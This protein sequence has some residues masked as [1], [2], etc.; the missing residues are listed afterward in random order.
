MSRRPFQRGPF[1]DLPE[2]PRRAHAW[3]EAQV[4]EHRV[5]SRAFGPV[6]IRTRRIGCGPPLVLVHGLMT[7]SYSWRHVL[8]P[9]AERWTVYAP[10]LVGAGESATPRGVYSGAALAAFLGEWLDAAGLSGSPTI[11]N[12]LGG[13]LAMRLALER[14]EAMS[15]LVN[16]HSPGFPEPRL[17]ALNLALRLPGLR[18]GLAAFVRREPERWAHRNVHYFDESLKSR[19]EARV[20]GAPLA[21]PE[22]SRAFVSWLGDALDP[23]ELADFVTRLERRRDRAEPFPVPLMLVYARQDP[24]VPPRIGRRL[25]A[26]LPGV[27][28]VW[29][30]DSSHFAHVD[31]P[32]ALLDAVRS[33][34]EA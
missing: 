23:R 16:I 1:A 27:P 24:M 17:R 14:P 2:V 30:E 18:R 20:Y 33:F 15:R 31:T 4:I 10:D 21:T 5:D 12:S 25:S 22:G 7:S 6:R 8:A 28:M 3:H 9:L 19:E 26:L 34:L 13:Y 29:L 32:E 11:A